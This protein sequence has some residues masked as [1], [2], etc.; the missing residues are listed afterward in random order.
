[1]TAMAK[2]LPCC[3][4]LPSPHTV[5]AYPKA[6]VTQRRFLPFRMILMPKGVKKF[7]RE[8]ENAK[9]YHRVHADSVELWVPEG[10]RH[11][12]E[13]SDLS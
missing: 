5:V 9:V 11:T 12:L 3:F 1:M 7:E 4:S 6:K 10:R 8:G 13:K 2:T